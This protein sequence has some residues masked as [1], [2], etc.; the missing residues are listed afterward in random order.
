MQTT[1]NFLDRN[2]YPALFIVVCLG[3]S[4]G[5]GIGYL[6]FLGLTG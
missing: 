6:M 1:R 2:F 3:A 5:A 4:A